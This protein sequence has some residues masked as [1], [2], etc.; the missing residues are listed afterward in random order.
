MISVTIIIPVYNGEEYLEQCIQSVFNQTLKEI[1]LIFIDDGSID[2]SA[3][4]IRKFADK[5]KRISLFWQ[6][7]QGPGPAKNFALKHAKG[8]YVTFLDADDYY[9]DTDALEKMVKACEERNVFVCA[10]LRKTLIHGKENEEDLFSEADINKV[11]NYIDFQM[12]YHYQSYL[13]HRKFLLENE[14]YFPNYR[15][16]EDPVF[17]PQTLLKAEKFTVINTHLYCYRMPL[18]NTRFTFEKTCDLLNGIKDNLNFSIKNELEILFKNTVYRLEYEYI[19]IILENI[20]TNHLDIIYLLLQINQ[21][22]CRQMKNEAYIIHPLRGVLLCTTGYEKSLLKKIQKEKKIVLYGAGWFGKIFF[23]YLK[24]YGLSDKVDAFI[25][26]KME[27]NF[28]YVE[29]IPVI[30]LEKLDKQFDICILVTVAE[31]KQEEIKNY[32]DKNGY[33]NYKTIDEVFLC[34]VADEVNSV[35]IQE[36]T[37]A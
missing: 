5:D 23:S 9:L 35:G 37:G 11:L 6:K 8:K 27:G 12:D 19:N 34:M 24:K 30:P 32:L 22:V 29:G 28:S 2:H 26:S 7:N 1:E 36:D 15:R 25:V 21:I 4:I 17:L 20:S 10:S 13:F 16:Y 3:Q 18:V 33:K 14:C 31:K